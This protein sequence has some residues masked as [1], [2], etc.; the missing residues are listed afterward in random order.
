MKNPQHTYRKTNERA[1]KKEKFRKNVDLSLYLFHALSFVIC[2]PNIMARM[3]IFLRVLFSSSVLSHF[4]LFQ[5]IRFG[6]T[7]RVSHQWSRQ[8]NFTQYPASL[9]YLWQSLHL[10]CPFYCFL[11]LFVDPIFIIVFF[12]LDVSHQYLEPTQSKYK[13]SCWFYAQQCS[14]F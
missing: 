9:I 13:K 3:V 11:F 1:K 8:L 10:I 2:V 4:F 12:L 14:F 5:S 7:A 6:W